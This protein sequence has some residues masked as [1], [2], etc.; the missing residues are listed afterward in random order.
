MGNKY[1]TSPKVVYKN[2]IV[3]NDNV[4]YI[5]EYQ[6][7]KEQELINAIIARKSALYDIIADSLGISIDK[8]MAKMS[9]IED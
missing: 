2:S 6:R 3:K 7:Y 1:K 4:V 5:A 8:I 9:D